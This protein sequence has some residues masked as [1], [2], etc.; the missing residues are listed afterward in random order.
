MR[1]ISAYI[2][3][4]DVKFA[5]KW[6]SALRGNSALRAHVARAAGLELARQHKGAPADSAT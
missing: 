3:Q 5:D 6:D 4:F 1:Q 2:S